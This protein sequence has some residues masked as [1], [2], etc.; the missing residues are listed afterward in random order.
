LMRRIHKATE[1][2]THDSIAET[3]NAKI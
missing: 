1:V 3:H 2:T